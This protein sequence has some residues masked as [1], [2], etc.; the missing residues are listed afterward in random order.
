MCLVIQEGERERRRPE[1]G[2][3]RGR[4]RE[5]E[6]DSGRIWTATEEGDRWEEGE[7]EKGGIEVTAQHRWAAEQGEREEERKR[8]GILVFFFK[9]VSWMDVH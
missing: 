4:D 5:K 2:V 6:T 8:E 1:V 7:W 3:W 9:G